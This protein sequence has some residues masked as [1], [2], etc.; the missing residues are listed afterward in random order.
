LHPHAA[1]GSNAVFQDDSWWSNRRSVTPTPDANSR[2]A[3]GNHKA[4]RPIAARMRHAK[5]NA[6]SQCLADIVMRFSHSPNGSWDYNSARNCDRTGIPGVRLLLPARYLFPLRSSRSRAT[7]SEGKRTGPER[8]L[9]AGHTALVG[10]AGRAGSDRV[11]VRVSHGDVR[12]V[13]G[14]HRRARYGLASR[15]SPRPRGRP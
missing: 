11:E 8:R 13:Y 1:R 6:A 4:A 7:E 14:A 2:G 12:R 5:P 10:A 9:G 3:D 15:R